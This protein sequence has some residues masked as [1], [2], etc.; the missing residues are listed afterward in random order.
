MAA[1]NTRRQILSVA[2]QLLLGRGFQGFS[3]QHI[4]E[5]LNIR[6]AAVHYHFPAKADLGLA[7]IKR[8]HEHFRWWAWQLRKQKIVPAVALE[9]FFATERRFL[10]GGTVCPLGVIT[11]ELQGVS[12]AMR[13]QAHALMDDV[14][15]WLDAVLDSGRRTGELEFGGASHERA[16]LVLSAL[17]GALQL[18]RLSGTEA[19]DRVLAL[20]RAD[21]G[22]PAQPP[23]VAG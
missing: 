19:F 12:P 22:L 7:L 1:K 15:A 6:N 5:R 17:Q 3:Y 21:L 10:E 20:V 4:A 9:R 14:L 13:A 23:G 8:H 2:E 11:V 18:A 16:L